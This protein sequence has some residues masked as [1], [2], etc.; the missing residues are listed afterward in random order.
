MEKVLTLSVL[1]HTVAARIAADVGFT[2]EID[3]VIPAGQ[4]VTI[5]V[6]VDVSQAKLIVFTC[7]KDVTVDPNGGSAPNSFTIAAGQGQ[8][9]FEGAAS[10]NFLSADVVSFDVTNDGDEDARFQGI[11]AIDPTIDAG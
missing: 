2:G 1:G 10:A 7:D 3:E 4:T 8:V 11:I 5:N 6:P 9:W